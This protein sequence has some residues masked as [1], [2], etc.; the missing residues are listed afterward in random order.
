MSVFR[1]SIQRQE[2]LIEQFSELAAGVSRKALI[3]VT[4]F[5]VSEITY[6][7]Y[8]NGYRLWIGRLIAGIDY[9]I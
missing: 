1:T 4:F 9:G 3:I 6:A 2:L 5:T 7:L 8:D